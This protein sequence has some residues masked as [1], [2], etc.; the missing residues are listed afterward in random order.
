MALE[1]IHAHLR[2]LTQ[3]VGRSLMDLRKLDN[4]V[5]IPSSPE[6]RRASMLDNVR[7]AR[8]DLADATD[9]QVMAAIRNQPK[10]PQ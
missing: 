7:R 1:T 2:G 3:E 10:A 6:Q 9:A 4:K 8:P 5:G